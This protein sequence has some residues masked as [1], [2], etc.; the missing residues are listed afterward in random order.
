MTR[1]SPQQFNAIMKTGKVKIISQ[2]G[3]KSKTERLKYW[4][5]KINGYDS[6]KENNRATELNMLQLAGKISNLIEQPTFRLQKSYKHEWQTIKGMI[7]IADF[8]YKKW[9][10]II[11]EDVKSEATRKSRTY[12]NKKKLFLSKYQDY[13][14]FIE[15]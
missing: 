5:I 1:I 2:T 9:D 13:Y 10:K 12:V 4:N 11:I 8:Q 6:T 7:Y 14:T 15:T 3:Q